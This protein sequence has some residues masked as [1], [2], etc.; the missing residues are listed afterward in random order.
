MGACVDRLIA[1]KWVKDKVDAAYKEA[2]IAASSELAELCGE[3]GTTEIACLTFPGA[4]TYKYSQTRRKTVVEWNLA[5]QE[6][7]NAWLQ[8]NKQAAIAYAFSAGSDFAKWW[9]ERTGELPDGVA[10]VEYEEPAKAGPPKLYKYDA[11]VVGD[12]FER[13]GGWLEGANRLLLGDA[14]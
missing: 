10:R 12:A 1:A 13:M 6:E 7:L 11:E 8:S 3:N 14:S 9:F 2:E 5:D 4:G